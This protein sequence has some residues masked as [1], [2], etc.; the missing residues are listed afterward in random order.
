MGKSRWS[1][2]FITGGATDRGIRMELPMCVINGV[3]EMFPADNR[4][5]M[6]HMENCVA[7][8]KFT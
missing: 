2:F 4:N 6:G 1:G 3:L 8:N 5:C 7:R